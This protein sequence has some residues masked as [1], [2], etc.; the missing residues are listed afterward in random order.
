[1]TSEQAVLFGAITATFVSATTV[2]LAFLRPTLRWLHAKLSAQRPSFPD[3]LCAGIWTSAIGAMIVCAVGC[4]RLAT[5]D[6]LAWI[7]TVAWIGVGG[8]YFLHFTAWRA[9]FN[10]NG[11]PGFGLKWAGVLALIWAVAAVLA[12][13]LL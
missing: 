3:R 1:M 4:W 2:A 8:G 9:S 10:D 11:E 12:G 6:L 7:A 13:N 5:G